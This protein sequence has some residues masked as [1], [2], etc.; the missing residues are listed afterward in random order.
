MRILVTARYISGAARE[1]GSSRFMRCV[2]DT[3][4]ELGHEVIA[5]ADPGK[6]AAEHFD[7]ILCSH[8]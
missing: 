4:A 2:A 3:L 1:G 5:T 7:L 6:R 8:P